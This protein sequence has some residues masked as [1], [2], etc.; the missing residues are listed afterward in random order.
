MTKRDRKL[1]PDRVERDARGRFRPGSGGRPPGA[2]NRA[3][4]AVEA[5]LDGEAETL[6]REAVELALAGEPTMLKF[7]LERLVPPRREASVTF[8]LPEMRK[9]A[10]AVAALGAVM[11]AVAS[12]EIT[13]SES[14][15]IAGVVEAFRRALDLEEIDARISALEAR[16]T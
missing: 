1:G 16:K 5:L 13:P 2:R 14:L 12:G 8:S 15:K 7:C 4:R 11:S 9:P 6:A 10:D 3:T